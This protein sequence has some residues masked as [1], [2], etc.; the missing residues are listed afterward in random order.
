MCQLSNLTHD[1]SG[2][3]TSVRSLLLLPVLLWL[4]RPAWGQSGAIIVRLDDQQQPVVAELELHSDVP[5]EQRVGLA[6]WSRDGEREMWRWLDA[7]SVWPPVEVDDEAAVG[8]SLASRS[9]GSATAGPTAAAFQSTV[10]LAQLQGAVLLRGAVFLTPV[11]QGT[12]LTG[13]PTLRR[14]PTADAAAPYPPRTATLLSSTNQVLLKFSFADRQAAIRWSDIPA[15]PPALAEGLPPGRYTLRLE[16]GL[17]GTQFTVASAAERIAA[18]GPADELTTLLRGESPAFL[19]QF[20]V[21]RLLAP[22]N[23]QGTP[24][25]LADALELLDSLPAEQSTPYLASL[26]GPLLQWLENLA[27]D[28]GYRQGRLVGIPLDSSTG[29]DPIDE[30]RT[31]IA[32]G[33]WS[34]ARE[35][36]GKITLPDDAAAARRLRGL[37]SL[38]EA[39][40]AS[41]AG[42]GRDEETEAAFQAAREDLA[43]ASEADRLRVLV[44]YGQYRLRQAQDRLHNHAFQMAA[45]VRLPLLSALRAW[46]A[47]RASF[48]DALPLATEP[49]AQAT[50]RLNLARCDAL[51][52]D[53]LDTLAPPEKD[54]AATATLRSRAAARATAEAR[55]VATADAPPLLRGAALE[56]QAQLAL[57]AADPAACREFAEAARAV[58]EP[59]GFLAGLEGLHRLLGL[60]AA[61]A[62][63]VAEARR[64]LQISQ[65]LAELLRE[66]YPADELGVSRAGFF[67]RRSYVYQ[68]LVELS[69]AARQPEVALR[70]AELAKA[71]SAQDLLTAAGQGGDESGSASASASELSTL[72]QAWPAK[73][74]AVEYFLGERGV[75]AF[76]VTPAGQIRAHA[77]RDAAGQPLAA[78]DLVAR[79]RAFL[80]R[81][82]NQAS[83]MAQSLLSGRGFDHRWQDD[84]HQFYGELWPAELRAELQGAEQVVVI[85]QHILHYF[86]FAAL[87]TQPDRTPRKKTESVSPRFLIDEPYHL[88]YAPSL[89]TWDLLRR[90][91]VRPLDRAQ[92]VGIVEVPGAP[93]LPGVDQ[94]LRNFQAVFGDAVKKMVDG[95]DAT[96]DQARR[97]LSEPG[98]LLLA[99]HGYNEP[100]RPLDSFLL[101]LPPTDKSPAMSES[102][103][104]GRL[105]ARDIFALRVRASMVVMSACFSGLG[106]RSPLPGDD[107]FGLQRAFLQS[108]ARVVVSGLWDVYDGTAPELIQAYFQQ[109]KQGVPASRALAL[110]QRQ[111]LAKLRQAPSPDVYLHPYFWA[112]YSVAGDDSTA[113]PR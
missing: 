57:R 72:L 94:D 90:R 95:R 4:A 88:I 69:L 46:T 41:E 7:T 22:R 51:L 13:R 25:Y 8:L 108:G 52:A 45:G 83:R 49:G 42:A 10:Q 86:P 96:A 91:P 29:S 18:L 43:E 12:V 78:R 97:I 63:D 48:A 112:V 9:T 47:A 60:N 109:V 103:Q 17:E 100:D 73:T 65:L 80:S 2:L 23:A 26:R 74:A 6:V 50:L 102:L 113:P 89:R 82:E 32:A 70:Y 87:V 77:L 14:L 39:V 93:P 21:E 106:D 11:H 110:S 20:R 19:A 61:A 66:R 58:Y 107:L 40:V 37:R 3:R 79:V 35:R 111:F 55:Q 56:L 75:W 71:R 62:G 101:F 33:R 104:A 99:T 5:V 53:L 44:N 92:A 85:P 84:L 15:L 68:N 16:G 105:T 24:T 30:V 81:T 54:A 67:A 36:L 31:A 98:V 64:R 28:P 76:V 34:D 1:A 59:A 38:Y 27:R